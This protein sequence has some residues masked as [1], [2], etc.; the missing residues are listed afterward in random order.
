MIS[1]MRGRDK[2]FLLK[3]RKK[4]SGD[5]VDLTNLVTA[6][7]KLAKDDGTY[8]TLAYPGAGLAISGDKSLPQNKKAKTN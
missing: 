8:L 4:T 5:P 7:I 6:S 2:T 1:I 3:L